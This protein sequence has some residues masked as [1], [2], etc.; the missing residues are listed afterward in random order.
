MKREEKVKEFQNANRTSRE[1]LSDDDA[2]DIV[3]DIGEDFD[4]DACSSIAESIETEEEEEVDEQPFDE[5]DIFEDEEN[6]T[7]KADQ[8]NQLDEMRAHRCNLPALESC[9]VVDANEMTSLP[10]KKRWQVFS[11]WK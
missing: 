6:F 5:E 7:L 3:E 8:K 1:V 11:H 9:L 10:V 4:G 2:S